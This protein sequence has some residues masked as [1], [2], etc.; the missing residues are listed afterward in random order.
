MPRLA[1]WPTHPLYS[2]EFWDSFPWLEWPVHEV[3][4][5]PPTS[6]KLKTVVSQMSVLPIYLYDGQEWLSLSST[7]T[8]AHD[9]LVYKFLFLYYFNPSS[10]LGTI[11]FIMCLCVSY[12]NNYWTSWCISRNWC[13]SLTFFTLFKVLTLL[14]HSLRGQSDTRTIA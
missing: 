13:K 8:T 6:A 2:C 9:I 7:L 4:H 11:K 5:S 14:L 3:D 10:L 1:V 12:P